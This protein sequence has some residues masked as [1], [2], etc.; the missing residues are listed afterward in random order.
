MDAIVDRADRGDEIALEGVSSPALRASVVRIADSWARSP[1]GGVGRD[2]VVAVLG[3]LARSIEASGAASNVPADG[4]KLLR[5]QLADLLRMELLQYEARGGEPELDDTARVRLLRAVET[6]QGS[7]NRSTGDDLRAR[8]VQPDA[9]ELIVEVAH[10]LRSPLTSILFLSETIRRGHSGEVT[11]LQHRQLGLVYSAALGLIS[12]ASDIMELARGG[13]RLTDEEPQPFSVHEVLESIREMVQIMA[14]EKHI[15]LRLLAPEGD[16]CLGYPVALSRTLLNLTT[17]AL[18]FT[19]EGLVEV[20]ARRINRRDVEFSVRDTGRGIGEEAQKTLF[21][22]FQ[23]APERSG[24]YFSGSGLGLSIA[25]RL[26]QAMGSD[27]EFETRPG[28]GTRF[29]FTLALPT[30]DDL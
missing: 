24:H 20:T 22:P 28:W 26:V 17:N 4:R 5:R 1:K 14:D 18:K 27:L 11:D 2:D 23:K 3:D 6:L 9:F 29:H 19:D 30:A 25:R 7:L 21:E 13:T 10:D 12:I 8:L 16:R 15:T